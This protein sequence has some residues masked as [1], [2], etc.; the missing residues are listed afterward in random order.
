MHHNFQ[1]IET[2]PIPFAA[3][4]ANIPR[5]DDYGVEFESDYVSPD[6]HL[7]INGSLALERGRV[8]GPFKTLDSTIANRFEGPNF[9]GGFFGPCA[10]FGSFGSPTAPTPA[11]LTCWNTVLANETNIQGNQPP[12][13]PNV[14]GSI[15]ASYR[16]DSPI[17][18][19]TPRVQVVYRGS[20]WA[21]IF[22]DPTLDKVPAYTVV[23]LNL[24]FVPTNNN[25]LRLSLTAT[26]VGNV[27]GI[28]SRYTDPFGTFTT[29]NQFIAPLQVIGTI[30][31]QY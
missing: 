7:V 3:G 27:A 15:A 19:F 4:L 25:H 22:D 31:L 9:T 14:T 24:D 29:S 12:D 30:A 1:Y 16:F 17:G 6:S 11:N 2:D 8:V 23:N 10:F 26:N 5:I 13:M 21:R 18:A 28:N 20:E